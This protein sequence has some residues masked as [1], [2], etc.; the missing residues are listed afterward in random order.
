MKLALDENLPQKVAQ[1]LA[2]LYYP[3][4][5]VLDELSRGTLDQR[6]FIE[7]VNRDWILVTHDKGMWRKKGHREALLQS[8]AG[9]FVLVSS[10]A[11]SPPD[12]TAL[13]LRRLPEMLTLG[14]RTKRPFVLRVPDR[15]KIGPF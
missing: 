5:H 10:V 14:Q 7:A 4:V 3:V 9:V 15:G 6:L 11:H 8:G 13:L 2:L 1:V 12:L